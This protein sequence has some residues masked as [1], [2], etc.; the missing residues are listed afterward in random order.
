MPWRIVLLGAVLVQ[1]LLAPAVGAEPAVQSAGEIIV[2]NPQAVFTGEWRESRLQTGYYGDD[3]R[4]RVAGNGSATARW[5]FRPPAPGVYEVLVIFTS[6]ENRAS[7]APYTVI[8]SGG[9]T[10]IAVNQKSGGGNWFSLGTFPF[11]AGDGQGVVLSDKADGV[12]VADAVKFVPRGSATP[13]PSP[14]PTPAPAGSGSPPPT[15]TSATPI[16]PA[17]ADAQNPRYFEQ[18]RYAISEDRFW[19]YFQKRGGVGTFG[20]PVSNTFTLLGMKVQIFQRRI[21]QLRP[22]GGVAIM[23]VLDEGLLPYNR[24]NGS[25]FPAPDPAIVRQHPVVGSP[26]YHERALKFVQDNTP[27][28][29][30]GLP[31]NFYRTFMNT[32]RYQDAYP[33]G[34]GDPG[35]MPGINLEVWG[36]PTSRPTYDPA[37]R[38]FVYMRFQRG[39]M[40]FDRTTG[41]TQGLLLADYF[42][43][44]LTGQN[45]PPD[46]EQQA[47]TS[48]FYRQYNSTQPLGM[49]RPNELPG[50]DL[51][52]AF[53][54]DPI[55]V[56][57]AGHGGAEIGTSHTFPD[58][59]TLREKDIN[60][61]VA[62]RVAALLQASGYSALLTRTTDSEVNRPPRDLTGDGR[63]N[64]SDELQARVDMANAAGA[65]LLLSIHFNGAPNPAARGTF[66]FYNDSRPFSDRN[67]VLAELT[68]AALV[69][70]MSE[71]GY[72]AV[73]RGAQPDT[74]VLSGGHYYLLGPASEII[75][76]PSTMPGII[77][78]PLFLTND[79]D[80]QA[81]RQD[82]VIEAIAQAYVEAVKA[83]FARYPD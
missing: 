17:S 78:E 16:T 79:E 81:A 22:D 66:V 63:V 7:N 47:R 64:L 26:G 58:G 23:N 24:M 40:H 14:S 13:A 35:L 57:D 67:K 4:Y 2:D 21:M 74:G 50:T 62:M 34:S 46:L 83:Y 54:R 9:T 10:Q 72:Q 68:A 48:R 73:N 45:L 5:P 65:S 27:D 37:N 76:R 56:V 25:T 11:S 31:V 32:V 20:Y 3:Y 18:T 1:V 52:N 82:K 70:R 44:V 12:V 41:L 39:I 60:L 53:R 61:R 49:N 15:S 75:K 42:K 8:Y 6:G 80:A 43:A 28:V 59:T 30:E 29:F 51:K 69:R 19:D 71:A 55:V 77:G 33:D 38:N 36:L